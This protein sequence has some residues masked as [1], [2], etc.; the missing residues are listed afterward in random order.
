MM[1]CRGGNSA[2]DAVASRMDCIGRPTSTPRLA[3]ILPVR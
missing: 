2:G 1:C 3:G